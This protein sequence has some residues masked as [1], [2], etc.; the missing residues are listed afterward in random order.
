MRHFQF[1]LMLKRNYICSFVLWAMLLF[2]IDALMVWALLL[3][4]P[5]R[6]V[7]QYFAPESVESALSVI[8]TLWVARRISNIQHRV[9]TELHSFT[10]GA[11][12]VD[13]A[14]T[15]VLAVWM[16]LRTSGNSCTSGDSCTSGKPGE[17]IEPERTEPTAD[18]M[19]A[20]IG[21]FTAMEEYGDEQR[22]QMLTSMQQ[23]M[24]KAK[25]DMMQQTAAEPE[26]HG[27]ATVA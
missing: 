14:L 8:F 25:K 19:P 15:S 27:T 16:S 21:P 18:I 26:L 7:L 5:S 9:A 17:P 10:T 4:A 22:R 20:D 24:E 11:C 3:H 12:T 1:T 6:Q 23:V 13:F 2:T